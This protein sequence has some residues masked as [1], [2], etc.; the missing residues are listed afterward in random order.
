[1]RDDVF[2]TD[3]DREAYL[4]WLKEYSD[5]SK[6]EVLAYCLM[7]NHVHLVAV[8][9]TDDG[10]QRMLKPLNMRYAQRI[11]RAQNWKGHVWQG[12]FFSSPL[13]DDYLWATVR[14]VERNPVRAGIVDRAENYRWSSAAAHC[15]IRSDGV[16]DLKSRWSKQFAAVE[17]WSAWLSEA[18]EMEKVRI[19]RQNSEKGL[20]CG[21]LDFIQ[22]LGLI[23]G[24]MLEFRP[25]G[26]PRKHEVENKG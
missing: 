2:F 22:R 23:V 6:V 7:T 20:P 8:P 5:K 16:L 24:R 19:L 10:L 9:E 4:L 14:Y 18:D 17:D 25:Q 13:D 3:E 1:R 12:R 15:G 11:N 21:N 26:R